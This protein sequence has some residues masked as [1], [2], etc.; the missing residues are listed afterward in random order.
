MGQ[1][2]EQNLMTHTATDTNRQVRRDFHSH[3]LPKIDDGA[4]T[5]DVSAEMLLSLGRQ[6]VETVCLTPHYSYHREPLDHFLARRQASYERLRERIFQ[7]QIT[8]GIPEIRLGAEV[9]IEPDLIEEKRIRELCYTGT[10]ALLLEFPFCRLESRVYETVEN[11][12]LKYKICPVIAHLDRYRE[13]FGRD[14][15]ERILNIPNVVVQVNAEALEGVFN[16]RFALSLLEQRV[17]LVLGSDAHNMDSRPPHIEKAYTV[18][19]AKLKDPERERFYR[20]A[21]CLMA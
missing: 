12:A 20:T 3:I 21:S 16:R 13:L 11:L 8:K 15:I 2:R 5:S 6:G 17:P 19:D 10:H 4:E 14:E 18:V 1:G 9:C 7:R